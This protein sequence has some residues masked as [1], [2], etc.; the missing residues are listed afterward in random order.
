MAE[1][2][3]LEQ[4]RLPETGRARGLVSSRTSGRRVDAASY[5]PPPALAAFVESLWVGRW[6]LR[7]QPPHHTEL[8]SD[9]CVNVVFEHGHGRREARVVGVW[10]RLWRRTLSERGFVRA[11]KLRAGAVTAIFDAPAAE[12]GNSI[13]PL[14]GFD[15]DAERLREAV[16]DPSDDA[17]GLAALA[18][19]LEARASGREDVGYREAVAL[20]ERIASDPELTSAQALA[21]AA[22]LSLRGLQRLFRTH[23][24]ATPKYVIRRNRLQEVATRIEQGEAPSL[25]ELAAELGY[26]DQAHLT[27][28]F[29]A[30]V[31]KS[32]RQFAASVG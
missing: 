11:A 5:V 32:P 2:L 20:V 17:E 28:D 27:R 3:K 15:P 26:A 30:I 29:K 19:W 8:L 6:D 10:T 24:G 7:G 22:G 31:G 18:R 23:V 4:T 12:L 13:V 14:A 21:D 25:A 1:R 16:L 9:P